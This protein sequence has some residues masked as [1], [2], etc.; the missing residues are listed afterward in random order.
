MLNLESF[1]EKY[2]YVYEYFGK[3]GLTADALIVYLT[4]HTEGKLSAPDIIKLTGFGR[5]KVYRILSALQR[6]ASVEIRS[7]RPA[8]YSAVP[9]EQFLM[10]AVQSREL[11]LKELKNETGEV[12]QNFPE[13]RVAGYLAKNQPD[14]FHFRFLDGTNSFLSTVMNL[15]RKVQESLY[16]ATGNFIF[17]KFDRFGVMPVVREAMERGVDVKILLEDKTELNLDKVNLEKSSFIRY[18]HELFYPMFLVK[19]GLEVVM[20]ME[21]GNRAMEPKK[22]KG[23]MGFWCISPSYAKRMKLLFDFVWEHM[24]QTV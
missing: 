13:K 15:T 1:K 5:A 20:L 21:V 11:E 17:S 6:S 18:S 2:P 23:P 10:E 16:I 22:R 4:I 19:D 12:A 24:S 14:D 3:L 9:I 7:G 8:Y